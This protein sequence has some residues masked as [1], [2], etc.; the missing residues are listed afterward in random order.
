MTPVG[1]G[2]PWAGLCPLNRTAEVR[3]K[4]TVGSGVCA[5]TCCLFSR[6]SGMASSNLWSIQSTSRSDDPAPPAHRPK[7]P[8]SRLN[9]MESW[10]PVCSG[11]RFIPLSWTWRRV[12][13]LIPAAATAA[14]SGS[15]EIQPVSAH[16]WMKLPRWFTSTAPVTPSSQ[17]LAANVS[18]GRGAKHGNMGFACAA[19]IYHVC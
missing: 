5:P 3:F 13:N 14:R 9:P 18:A 4:Q 19:I 7:L 11:A 8:I 17:Q 10:L 1:P 2:E 6:A 15:A 12:A 16:I